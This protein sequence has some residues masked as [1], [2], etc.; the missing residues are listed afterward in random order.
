MNMP[1]GKYR[2]EPLEDLPTS[3]L[4]WLLSETDIDKKNPVLAKECQDQ[5]DMRDGHGVP[6]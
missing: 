4:T 1:F 3:Y 5:L 6:R 2:G